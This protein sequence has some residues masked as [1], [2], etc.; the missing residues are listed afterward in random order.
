M[1]TV[2]ASGRTYNEGPASLSE[3]GPSC[4]RSAK[5]AVQEPC[6]SVSYAFSTTFSQL[7]TLLTNIS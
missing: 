5:I 6:G 7:S 2:A 4:G 1:P 3:A